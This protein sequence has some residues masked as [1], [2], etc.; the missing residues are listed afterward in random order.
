M[1]DPVRVA[2]G[3]TLKRKLIEV[4][5]FLPLDAI[6]TA[7]KADKDKKTGTIKNVHKWFAPMPTP[8]LRALIF[9]ALVDAP[10][11]ED[12]KAEL[13]RLVERLVP[14]DGKPPDAKT[15]EEA[16][17]EIRRCFGDELPTVFD[18]FCGGGSTLIEAQRLGLPAVGSDLNPVPVLITRTLTELIPQVAGRP[19]LVGDPAQLALM[20]GGPLDGLLADVRHYAEVIR[21]RVWN[22]TGHLYPHGPNG[23]T[24][25]AWLWTREVQCQN[26]GCGKW[27]PLLSTMWLS[28]KK[29]LQCYVAPCLTA[30][31][32]ELAIKLG[33]GRP[34]EPPKVGRGGRF[35]CMTCRE[36]ADAD[37]IHD[38]I[39]ASADRR[40]LIAIVGESAGVRSYL[41]PRVEDMQAV[42]EARRP[43][44]IP[45]IPCRGTFGSNAQGRRYGFHEVADYFTDRQLLVLR[46]F[47]KE[48]S[49]VVAQ[50]ANSEDLVYARAIGSILTLALG[51]LAQANSRLVRWRLRAVN[52]K[53]EPAFASQGVPFVWDYAEVNP[54]GGSVGDWLAQVESISGGLS[55]LPDVTAPAAVRLSDARQADTVA[56]GLKVA[57]VTDPPYFNQ[58]AYADISDYFYLWHRLA[59]REA[60]PDLYATMATPKGNELIASAHRHDGDE[61][62]AHQYFVR[63]FT[64]VFGRLKNLEVADAP[65]IVVYAHKQEERSA[66]GNASTG[67]D[68]MLGAILNAGLT[69]EATL[70][71]RG[72]SSSKIIGLGRNALASY[73][74]MVC[75]PRPE[76]TAPATLAEFRGVLRRRLPDAVTKLL[77]SGESMVDIRHAAIGPGLEVFSQYSQVFDGNDPIPVRRSLSIINQELGRLLDEQLGSVDDETRWACQWYA[78]HGF[79]LGD[80]G[81]ALKGAASF[82]LGMDGLVKAGIVE[83]HRG[84]VR[85]VPQEELPVDW[86]GDDRTPTWEACQHL[87]RRLTVGTD[88]GEEA[89]GELLAKLGKKAAGVRELAQYLTNLA[90][91]KGWSDDA[92]AYDALVKSWPRLEEIAKDPAL[93]PASGTLFNI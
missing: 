89:A 79:G 24:I 85:L 21:Q 8:A 56:R 14:P 27:M 71:V 6:S 91:E 86:W 73:I 2:E 41:S 3:M 28:T 20:T 29:D 81:L 62:E 64:D 32:V 69:I 22:E 47:A 11:D 70:P 93:H 31:G 18:P 61:K 42:S 10:D 45:S 77:A 16:K 30:D 17:A 39:D 50:L 46:S 7:S 36:I 80:Y 74:V 37:Y 88:A 52:S 87:V 15:L 40:R 76:V 1:L 59:L 33:M 34:E 92:I 23:E 12:R 68:A 43:L 58:V 25:I 67:W 55:A 72:S 26:P 38:K 90:I 51:K 60:L 53:A 19:P 65:C 4:A 5:P 9:A 48:I 66:F 78:D 63:G 35:R 57:V 84:D 13:L 44:D 82:G 49:S 54:F 83:S 75:R